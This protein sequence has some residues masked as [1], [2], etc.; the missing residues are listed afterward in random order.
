MDKILIKSSLHNYEVE[1]IDDAKKKLSEIAGN[2]CTF[3]I[4]KNVYELHKSVFADIDINLVYFVDAVESN[5]NIERCLDLIAFWQKIE[6]KKN[7]R[8][9]CFGGGITQDITTFSSNIYLRNIEW[10]FFPTTLL[11]MTDSCIGGKSGINLGEYKNQLGVFY[12]P[13][14]IFICDKFLETLKRA[15][16]INGWGELLKFSLTETKEFY[17]ELSEEVQYIPCPNIIK[18]IHAGLM[19]KKNIIEIDEFEGD[20]RRILNFG[21]TFGHALESLSHNRIPHG[22]AVMWGIDVANY[23]AVRLG[24]LDRKIYNEVKA[25]IKNEFITDEIVVDDSEKIIKI[26]SADKKV[27]QNTV[28]LVLL[29]QFSKL[30]IHPMELNEE[31]QE[32]FDDYLNETHTYYCS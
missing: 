30:V 27:R 19:V 22:T 21:H 4:D 1:F 18:Y 29:S 14:K 28:Y 2:N 26:L 15:D 32:L 9:L 12:P 13:K 11:A 23:I 24:V 10:Y 20:L 6:L 7:W 3:V 8:V 5:K 25:L 17:D 31:L 16:Y